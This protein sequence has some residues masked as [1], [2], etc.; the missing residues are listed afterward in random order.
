M[1]HEEIG[2]SFLS[3]QKRKRITAKGNR[4]VLAHKHNL[5]KTNPAQSEVTE[6]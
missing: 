6:F 2:S 1:S 4:G 5:E 3:F